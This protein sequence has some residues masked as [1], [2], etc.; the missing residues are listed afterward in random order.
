MATRPDPAPLRETAEVAQSSTQSSTQ[1]STQSSAQSSTEPSTE[2][3]AVVLSGGRAERLQGADK[4][5]LEVGGATLLDHVL[6]A[7]EDV[8]EVVVV[9]DPV[10]TRRAVTFTREDPAGGGPAAA[11]LAGVRALP[12][13]PR[14]LV[15]MAVDAPLVTTATVSRLLLSSA[16]HG[17]LLVDGDGRRQYLCAVYLT[18]ALLAAAPVQGEEHGLAVRRLV[19]DLDLAEVPALAWET[20]DVDTWEDLSALRERLDG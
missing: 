3:A 13:T 20:R 12:R 2:L 9:G 4:A 15:V 11:I 17:A 5:T 19:A 18:E 16:E 6:A 1:P 7:L 8:A 14:L 10:P